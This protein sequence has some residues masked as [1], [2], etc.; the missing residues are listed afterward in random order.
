MSLEKPYISESWITSGMANSKSDVQDEPDDV[1]KPLP[2]ED[3]ISLEKNT[4]PPPFESIS[5]IY[6]NRGSGLFKTWDLTFATQLLI[7]IY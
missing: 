5:H 6:L 3:H 1:S 2:Y 7:L 4:R